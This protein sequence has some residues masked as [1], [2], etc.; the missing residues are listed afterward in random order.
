MACWFEPLRQ[1][2]LGSVE[3]ANIIGIVTA[4]AFVTSFIT[5]VLTTVIS[6]RVYIRLQR[7]ALTDVFILLFS[8]A[9]SI[10]ELIEPITIFGIPNFL[11]K[12]ALVIWTAGLII[13][14]WLIQDVLSVDRVKFKKPNVS[15]LIK[16]FQN[17]DQD[18][19]IVQSFG[20]KCVD[21]E[22][23]AATDNGKPLYFPILLIAQKYFRPWRMAAR[24]AVAGLAFE[25]DE[26]GRVSVK[27][28]II[29]FAFNQPAKIV[30]DQLVK[31]LG[32]VNPK[33]PSDYKETSSGKVPK[34]FDQVV[35]IDCHSKWLEKQSFQSHKKEF[36]EG[37]GQVHVLFSDPRDPYDLAKKYK[38]AIEILL[39]M[40]I[41][42]IRVVYDSISDFLVYSDPQLA[43]QFIKHNMVWED[44]TKIS[45][46]YVYIPGVP[47]SGENNPVDEGFLRWNSYCVVEFKH[48]EPRSDS[49]I[50]EG[51][52][53]EKIHKKVECTP[54]ADYKTVQMTL[55][56]DQDHHKGRSKD[57]I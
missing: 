43:L 24:F 29:Y 41:E 12:S 33:A 37:P 20:L 4:I 35:V 49:M 13:L 40:N 9:L 57:I 54:E 2:I 10:T 48:E 28:G 42:R 27:E 46:L 11:L 15:A 34:K 26:T 47:Q 55:V 52:L 31:R 53:E 23:R 39:D 51:L 16:P 38:R 7:R 25:S 22:F 6:R 8:L 32:M 1:Y 36:P 30:V 18:H 56:S 21:D 19:K 14:I 44:E 3:T 45:S 50:L 5:Y 17:T